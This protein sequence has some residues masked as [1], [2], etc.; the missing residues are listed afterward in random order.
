MVIVVAAQGS[1]LQDKIDAIVA[2]YK[3]RFHQDAVGVVIRQA[4][5]S[6]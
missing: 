6:F 2:E 1:M 3:R 4:C 5:V